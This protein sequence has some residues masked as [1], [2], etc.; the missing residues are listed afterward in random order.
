MRKENDLIS[1][2]SLQHYAPQFTERRTG[3]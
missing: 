2:Y 1:R 3:N